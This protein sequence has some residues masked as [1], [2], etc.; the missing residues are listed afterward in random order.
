MQIAVPIGR[1]VLCMRMLSPEVNSGKLV[2]LDRVILEYMVGWL[3]N[4]S[5]HVVFNLRERVKF[6]KIALSTRS[7][8]RN[9]YWIVFHQTCLL[10]QVEIFVLCDTLSHCVLYTDNRDFSPVKRKPFYSYLVSKMDTFSS[11]NTSW[12]MQGYEHWEHII[13]YVYT[14]ILRLYD[15]TICPE[16]EPSYIMRIKLFDYWLCA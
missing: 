11:I 4:L 8:T 13:D 7:W 15:I 10:S 5:W 3:A 14:F 12:W 1:R 6:G 2:E 9:P 16:A